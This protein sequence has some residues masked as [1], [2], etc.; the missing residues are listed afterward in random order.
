MSHT[1]LNLPKASSCAE[2][3]PVV[4]AVVRSSPLLQP[5]GHAVAGAL[6]EWQWSTPCS[7]I[8]FESSGIT[9]IL[10]HFPKATWWSPLVQMSTANTALTV[11]S[12]FG[13]H[14]GI[15]RAAI[16]MDYQRQLMPELHSGM[17]QPDICPASFS[18]IDCILVPR[19]VTLRPRLSRMKVQPPHP[20]L[21]LLVLHSTSQCCCALSDLMTSILPPCLH[22]LSNPA[23]R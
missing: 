12:D 21:S 15:C 19:Y 6:L 8:D 23:C 22:C 3:Y 18:K 5:S 16:V 11:T 9:G 4:Q 2:S 13:L 10:Q 7:T 20:Q 17:S 14:S 1:P